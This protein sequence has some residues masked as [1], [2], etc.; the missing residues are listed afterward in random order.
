MAN[1]PE[2]QKRLLRSMGN[3]KNKEHNELKKENEQLKKAIM[4]ARQYY[5]LPQEVYDVFSTLVP[6]PDDIISR[7]FLKEIGLE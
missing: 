5:H 2:S 6:G 1:I 3:K 7:S 4:F